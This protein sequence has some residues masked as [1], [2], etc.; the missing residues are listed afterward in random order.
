MKMETRFRSKKSGANKDKS[1]SGSPSTK[2]VVVDKHQDAPVI[3]ESIRFQDAG[4]EIPLSWKLSK[5][6]KLWYLLSWEKLDELNPNLRPTLNR[7]FTR[8]TSADSDPGMP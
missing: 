3:I 7:Y 6:Q 5:Q 1:T 2:A 8:R 4:Q